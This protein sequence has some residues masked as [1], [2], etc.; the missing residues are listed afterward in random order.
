M[1]N[2]INGFDMLLQKSLR[3]ISGTLFTCGKREPEFMWILESEAKGKLGIDLGANIGYCTLPL[4]KR[5]DRVIAIEPD[6]KARNILQKN[7][8]LNEKRFTGTRVKIMDVAVSDAVGSYNIYVNKESNLTSM[9]EPKKGEFSIKK[10]KCITLDSLGKL[11]NFIKMDVEGYEVEVINGALECLKETPHCKILIEVH[12]ITYSESHS[13]ANV[14]RKLF[15]LGYYFKY[16]VSAGTACPEPIRQKGYT[17]PIKTF[18]FGPFKRG[19]YADI[20]QDDALD[21]CSRTHEHYFV[22]PTDVH[23][24]PQLV[25]KAVRSILLVKEKT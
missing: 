6:K 7:I 16:V 21:L 10:I 20:K 24:I 1:K 3:G 17:K 15:D 2:K 22:D 11:P 4:C 14:V 19:I 23:K 9:I 13:F 25:K 5:M 12:P 8:N 18:K